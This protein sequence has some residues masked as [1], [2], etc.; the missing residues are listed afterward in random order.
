MPW[1]VAQKKLGILFRWTCI[2]KHYS[3]AFTEHNA[4]FYQCTSSLMQIDLP[5]LHSD[6]HYCV[7]K[8]LPQ[9]LWAWAYPNVRLQCST[10]EL[11]AFVTKSFSSHK[12]IWNAMLI[13]RIKGRLS[14]PCMALHMKTYH[15][16]CEY[17]LMKLLHPLHFWH[18]TRQRSWGSVPASLLLPHPFCRVSGFFHDTMKLEEMQLQHLILWQNKQLVHRPWSIIHYLQLQSLINTSRLK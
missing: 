16:T 15:Q 14:V 7:G 8:S 4:A 17:N 5:H 10:Q 3:S 9:V 1:A 18:T 6:M 2:S 11:M 12:R 13:A